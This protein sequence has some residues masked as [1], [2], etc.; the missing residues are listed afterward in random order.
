MKRKRPSGSSTTNLAE[1]RRRR[2]R[3][4]EK[5]EQESSSELKKQKT[6][7]ERVVGAPKIELKGLRGL[8]PDVLETFRANRVLYAPMNTA[9]QRELEAANIR[10]SLVVVFESVVAYFRSHRK[11]TESVRALCG[12]LS[13]S[14]PPHKVG[15]TRLTAKQVKKRLQAL[16]KAAP[17]FCEFWSRRDDLSKQFRVKSLRLDLSK[18]RDALSVLERKE[19][20]SPKATT[21]EVDADEDGQEGIKREEAL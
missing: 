17:Q 13:S 8:E 19:I 18:I 15:G 16:E 3:E 7:P 2:E 12:A 21:D 20:K 11:T 9:N 5:L 14:L 4:K 1:L 10:S 6:E